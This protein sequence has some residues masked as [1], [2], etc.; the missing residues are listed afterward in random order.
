MIDGMV[1]DHR[2]FVLKR[3]FHTMPTEGMTARAVP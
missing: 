3:A 1:R 2:G